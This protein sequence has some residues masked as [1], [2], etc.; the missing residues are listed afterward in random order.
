MTAAFAAKSHFIIDGVREFRG[1]SYCCG[2][3]KDEYTVPNFLQKVSGFSVQ[4][5]SHGES[6]PLDAVEIKHKLIRPHNAR[7]DALNGAQS[8][9]KVQDVP[10]QVDYLVQQLK[11][12]PDIDY[13]QDW[14]LL[15]ILIGA[16]NMGGSCRNTSYSHPDYY[17]AQLR[18]VLDQVHKEIPRV[19]VNLMTGFNISQVWNVWSQDKYCLDFHKLIPQEFGCI[20]DGDEARSIL[21]ETNL[22]Y[23][24]RIR[25]IAADWK[26]QNLTDFRVQV[27][28]AL[29]EMILLGRE[30]VSELDC[31][32]PSYLAHAAWSI[33]LWNNMLTPEGQKSK[34]L[35][36]SIKFKCPT[37][38][39]YIQ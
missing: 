12:N 33:A 32:H 6:I 10:A 14:K 15:T 38:T 27:Q 28:P 8:Q 3:D 30:Y 35:D 9:A 26:A 1:L 19:F 16:N 5:E 17:E 20:A 2:G 7:V 34:T 37:N 29:E 39:S 36:P 11:A 25:K 24:K 22:E 23:N 4:G 31:L 21:A 18:A 13:D